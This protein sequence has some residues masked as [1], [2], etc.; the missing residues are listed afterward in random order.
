MAYAMGY[1]P[2]PLTGL[3][4]GLADLYNELVLRIIRSKVAVVP[5]QRPLHSSGRRK[6]TQKD[7]KNEDRTDYVYENTRNS[8]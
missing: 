3:R 8:N 2:T 4:N 6:R 7:V 1:V 5:S